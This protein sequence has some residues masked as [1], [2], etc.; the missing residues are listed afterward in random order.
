M[1]RLLG[2]IALLIISLAP[3]C[4]LAPDGLEN[5]TASE[6]TLRDSFEGQAPED[7]F[8]FG[9]WITWLVFLA[10][11]LGILTFGWYFF[12]QSSV[13]YLVL[14][15]VAAF[16][17]ASVLNYFGYQRAYGSYFASVEA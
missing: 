9:F 5:L 3:T 12:R 15:L 10:L 17:V 4:W 2:L 13:R 6:A 14:G 11:E 8:G 16:S 1:T 7:V